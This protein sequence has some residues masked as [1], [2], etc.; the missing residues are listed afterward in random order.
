MGGLI[1]D[2]AIHR[3]PQV[4]GRAGVLSPAY[5]TADPGIYDYAAKQPLAAGARVY[6]S[7]GSKED[8]NAV[9]NAQRMH[10]LAAAQRPEPG[11][12][13][14]HIVPDAKHNEAAWRAELPKVLNFLFAPLPS[15]PSLPSP[16]AQ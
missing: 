11:A 13:T 7:M 3:Y 4:F 1:S 2:Y 15:P 5:W 6:F 12:V 14:L 8:E 10:T 9:P 16:T